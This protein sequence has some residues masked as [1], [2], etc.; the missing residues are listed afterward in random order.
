MYAKLI[1]FVFMFKKIEH[2]KSAML[3][4]FTLRTTPS[5]RNRH[6]SKSGSS[7]GRLVEMGGVESSHILHSK[8]STSTG[9][10]WF[11]HFDPYKFLSTFE[12]SLFFVGCI[13]SQTL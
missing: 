6:E 3:Y 4:F 12:Y 9:V 2:R 10:T 5:R 13:A 11:L 7:L 1:Y 8:S